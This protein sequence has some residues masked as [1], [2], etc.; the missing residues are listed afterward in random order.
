MIGL[1]NKQRRCMGLEEIPDNWDRVELADDCLIY[2]DGDTIRKEIDYNDE[3]YRE[4]S[5][6]I[7][8]E[9]NRSM[10][11]PKTCRGKLK[12]LTY[13]NV[14]NR[15]AYGMYFAWNGK[16]GGSI[17]LANYTTQVT[18]YNSEY[19]GI[20]ICSRKELKAWLEQ[21]ES[22]TT[23]ER[24]QEVQRFATAPRRHCKYQEGDFFRFRF[25]RSHYGYGRILF[26]VEAWKKRGNPFW[27]VLMG[28]VLVVQ[29]YH[30]VTQD[31]DISVQELAALPACPSQFIMDNLFY[32]GEC[33]I[34][35]NMPLTGE[36]DYPIMYG[37][38]I[39]ALEPDKMIFCQG[40]VYQEF[41]LGKWKP[42]GK[43]GENYINNSVGWGLDLNKNVIEQCIAKN[44]NQPYWE[45]EQFDFAGDLRN[46]KNRKIYRKLMK[47]MEK[48]SSMENV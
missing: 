19:E 16:Y 25:D 7:E 45:Q 14:L 29:I 48:Q 44:S 35:G 36:V 2:F 37:R 5:V 30:I 11:V 3:W 40:K 1:T 17:T 20:S 38:S 9:Q 47:Q 6:Q 32:Y 15:P 8:T 42:I 46:P 34:I 41:P 33:E 22:E 27:D 31:L 26:D 10:I 13:S 28:K 39:S 24:L 23:E 12:K 4:S 21:W 43:K 18:Y